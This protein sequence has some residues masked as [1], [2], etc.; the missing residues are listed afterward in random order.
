MDKQEIQISNAKI[1]ISA[2]H[3]GEN[4]HGQ[5]S[6]SYRQSF[7]CGLLEDPAG[8]LEELR[9]YSCRIGHLLP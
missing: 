9:K 3:K 7:G 2:R 6:E 4:T 5:K 1:Q 8:V